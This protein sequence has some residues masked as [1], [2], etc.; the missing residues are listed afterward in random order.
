MAVQAPS[1][2]FEAEAGELE[3]SAHFTEAI[4]S[5]TKAIE[6]SASSA[7]PHDGRRRHRRLLG[8][9]GFGCHR[10]IAAADR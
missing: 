9:S 7:Q 10:H 8:S 4:V 3:P 2:A 5:R 1:S 6:T